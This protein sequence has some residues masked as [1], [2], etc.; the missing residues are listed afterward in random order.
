MMCRAGTATPAAP[1]SDRGI[2]AAAPLPFVR[3]GIEIRLKTGWHTYW[4]Y[5][6]D[7]GVPPQF[8]FAGSQNVKSVDVLWPAPQRLPEAWRFVDRLYARRHPAAARW[9]RRTRASR[10]RCS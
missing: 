9:Y 7:A 5:P 6:G 2:A 4:R 8:D 10:S 1:S 3:A